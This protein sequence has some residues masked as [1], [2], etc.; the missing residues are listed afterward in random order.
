[1]KR[2]LVAA[3]LAALAAP[4]LAHARDVTMRVQDVPLGVRALASSPRPA[5]FN[6][7]GLHWIGAGRVEY[8]TR[9]EGGPWRVWRTADADNATGAWH[10]G[11]L[12]WTGPS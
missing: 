4:S 7:L 12:D 10:D 3:G 6:L 11:S 1:M 8:R 9:A 5:R 2:L